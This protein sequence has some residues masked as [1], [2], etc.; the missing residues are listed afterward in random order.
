MAQGRQRDEWDRTVELWV[1]LANAYRDTKQVPK[2]Y[3]R[4]MIHPLRDY[5]DY[6][7]PVATK[8]HLAAFREAVTGGTTHA[9]R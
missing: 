7:P 4:D 6:K 1:I 3:T 5:D 2:P 9:K 8:A